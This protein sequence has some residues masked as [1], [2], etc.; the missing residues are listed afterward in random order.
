MIEISKNL[1][2]L[3]D[4]VF[5]PAG[6]DIR[7]V[8]GS[9]RDTL[10][11]KTPKDIDLCTDATPDE[12][13]ALY[14]QHGVFFYETGLKHGTV[15]ISLGPKGSN[16]LYE[17]TSLR[18][19]SNHDGRWAE[20]QYIRDW[21][22]DLARRDLTINAM[23]M[24]FEG[25]LYDPFNGHDDLK[26]KRVR[27]V[28]DADARMHEDYLRILRWFRFHG[29][30][31]GNAPLDD[32]T[33]D[34]VERCAPHLEQISR[35]RVWSEMKQIIAHDTGWVMLREMMR[36]GVVYPCGLPQGSF[37]EVARVAAFTRNPVTLFVAYL[38]DP[39]R[40]ENL[41]QR[42][43]WSGEEARLARFL[44]QHRVDER[45]DLR[46][47]LAHEA[48][49]AAKVFELARLQGR[50]AE[51]DALE[52]WEVPTFPV[53][54]ADLVAA[55]LK[56]SPMVSQYLAAMRVLWTDS[57]YQLD[58]ETLIDQVVPKDELTPR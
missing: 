25:T 6:F 22:G 14:R 53:R 43:R 52:A 7:L 2:D 16:E 45:C 24:D 33:C 57:D 21:A 34:A 58:R 20:V 41:A 19:E 37:Y 31:A 30:I 55:G 49:D 42:W 10:M 5:A 32:E 56:P 26:A 13:I 54:G 17:I 15:T 36:L 18:S 50:M 4:T 47:M 3:R 12:Q 11:G 1:R 51:L 29:R 35:E 23:A 8:G 27:F 46:R 39:Q 44:A 9:V 40:V 28:G 48:I 38:S